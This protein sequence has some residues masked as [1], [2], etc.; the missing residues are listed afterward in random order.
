[1]LIDSQC[2]SICARRFCTDIPST[3]WL[4]LLRSTLFR[5]DNKFPRDKMRSINM[6]YILSTWIT[7]LLMPALLHH[8]E[9]PYGIHHFLLHACL[10][11]LSVFFAV[12]SMPR[13]Y[14]FLIVQPFPII[15]R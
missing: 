11:M 8:L 14:S 1:M 5:A 10:I 12:H 4:P 15:S 6:C 7:F 2:S 13:C 3:P 9:V